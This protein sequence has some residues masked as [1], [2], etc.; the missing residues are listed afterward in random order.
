MP[1]SKQCVCEAPDLELKMN[2]GNLYDT[3]K[4]YHYGEMLKRL[5]SVD[6]GIIG[7]VGYLLRKL[8]CKYESKMK[9]S[10][11]IAEGG[12]QE[13]K[14]KELGIRERKIRFE[15]NEIFTDLVFD[16]YQKDWSKAYQYTFH[17]FFHIIDL[18]ANPN[19]P[20]DP[21][22]GCCFSPIYKNRF[23][24][25]LSPE[26]KVTL[27]VARNEK[28]QFGEIIIKDIENLEKNAE[29]LNEIHNLSKH[30][31]A[32]LYDAIGGFFYHDKYPNEE[33]PGDEILFPKGKDKYYEQFGHNKKYWL[34]NAEN[35]FENF[36][37]RLA[38]EVFAHMAA[39]AVANTSAFNAMKKYLPNSYRMFIEILN[40]M[41]MTGKK[42]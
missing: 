14:L 13:Q 37:G 29:K 6:K 36:P 23:F 19:N 1:K 20:V 4:D 25:F 12:K 7:S 2:K 9:V 35:D 27:G 42:V 3:L 33:R 17:E 41:F 31:K 21:K 34:G 32:P 11:T 26:G 5:N 22:E 18:L 16:T 40:Y 24:K 28:Y 15:K 10:S 39:T 8:W 38:M 30:D